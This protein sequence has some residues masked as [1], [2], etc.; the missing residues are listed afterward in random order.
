MKSPRECVKNKRE[1][2][3]R[4]SCRARG[5]KDGKELVKEIEKQQQE[6]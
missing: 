5:Y 2:D 3:Q 4:L 1:E 6:K